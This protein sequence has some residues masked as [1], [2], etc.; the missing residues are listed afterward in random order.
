[1]IYTCECGKTYKTSSGF[2][3]HQEKCSSLTVSE[4]EVE[5]I[6]SD[7]DEE[8]EEILM[9]LLPK[10]VDE[11][12]EDLMM[13][14]LPKQISMKVDEVDEDELCYSKADFIMKDVYDKK[15]KYLQTQLF[16]QHLPK[17]RIK[18]YKMAIKKLNKKTII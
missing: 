11:V 12:D 5:E 7:E 8:V 14:L 9:P 17:K 13:T 16:K 15:L 18:S 10:Q 6:L 4:E 3:R 2:K 1:M